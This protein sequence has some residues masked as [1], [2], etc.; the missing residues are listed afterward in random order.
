MCKSDDTAESKA[1]AEAESDINQYTDKREQNGLRARTSQIITDGRTDNIAALLLELKTLESFGRVK[2]LLDLFFGIT[3]VDT[4]LDRKNLSVVAGLDERGVIERI[5]R[6]ADFTDIDLAFLDVVYDGRSARQIDR[7]NAR[8]LRNHPIG[9]QTESRN[10]YNGGN[11]KRL[12]APGHEIDLGILKE[13]EHFKRLRTVRINRVVENKTGHHDGGEH[14]NYDAARKHD[15]KAAN[16]ARANDEKNDAGHDRR[17]VRVDNRGKGL[18][19]AY[20]DCLTGRS[21]AGKLLADALVNENVCVDRHTE[22]EYKTG[23]T[24]H[25]QHGKLNGTGRPIHII[26]ENTEDT[27]HKE[28][29]GWKQNYVKKKRDICYKTGS[30]IVENHKE[31]NEKESDCCGINTR[32]D[33][34]RT[35]SS[36]NFG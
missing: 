1:E 23:N 13:L 8:R 35:Y 21:A 19:V 15:G 17:D 22:R 7:E 34:I 9:E 31:R 36:G 5:N 28:K 11:K 20:A 24:G 4:G 18:T 3:L 6:L 14:R 2:K 27:R 25:R 29:R 12:V 33:S 30:P 32:I 26:N 10:D 16:R